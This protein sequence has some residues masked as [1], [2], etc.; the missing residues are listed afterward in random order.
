MKD[1]SPAPEAL[2][3]LRCE[4]FIE[5]SRVHAG[6]DPMALPPSERGVYQASVEEGGGLFRV[7]VRLAG[8][9]DDE[10]PFSDQ[11][12]LLVAIEN[13]KPAVYLGNAV[14]GDMLV[15][16]VACRGGLYFAPTMC[17]KGLVRGTP[18]DAALYAVYRQENTCAITHAFIEAPC[19]TTPA[20]PAN[21]SGQP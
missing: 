1:Q 15:K 13:G 21:G 16:V 3:P 9:A 20:A 5:D 2:A 14:D 12:N 7:Q 11:L 17:D 19:Q 18:K 8:L 4:R 10:L 6:Y